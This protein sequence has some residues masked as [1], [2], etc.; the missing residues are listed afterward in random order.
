MNMKKE[1]ID[2]FFLNTLT[3]YLERERDQ[4]LYIKNI[5]N[6][7]PEMNQKTISW[8]MY[9]LVQ[10]GKLYRTGHGY[11]SLK[12]VAE[13]SSAGY[14]YLQKSSREIYD[15]VMEFGYDFYI[16]G[17]D[18]LTGEIL[19][20]PEQFPT[21]LVVEKD[22]INE[23]EETLNYQ[24]YFVLSEQ[25]KGFIQY[26]SF[27]NKVQVIILKGTNFSFATDNIANKEKAFVDLYYAVTR[28][29]YAL[30][31]PE[32]LR[33]YESMKR[34]DSIATLVM[35]KAA[36]DRGIATEINWMLE[37]NKMTPKAKEVFEYQL[38]EEQW[39]I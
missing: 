26:E 8:R 7:F 2:D 23:I 36:K 3:E 30:S 25:K 39:K 37:L 11:Y 5:Y 22:G 27:R 18:A 17:M 20:I 1:T 13:H 32:L 34:N 24:G 29:D 35:K 16:T 12:P 33:I 28:L 38:K 10:Q 21:I 14:N 31:V 9:K 15:K 19:H 4:Q 6:M